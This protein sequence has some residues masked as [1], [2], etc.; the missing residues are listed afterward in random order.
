MIDELH[1]YRGLFGSHVA[2]V[3]RRL[4]RICQFYGA[5]PVFLCCSATIA[6][7][8]EL[9][10]RLCGRRPELVDQS[11]APRGPRTIALY[12]PP[13]VKAQLGLRQSVVTAATQIMERLQEAPLQSICFA[14]SRQ[15]VEILTQTLR[16][17]RPTHP[18]VASPVRGYR[19]GYL[20]SERR[21][22]E[23]GLRDG[24]IATVVATNALELGVDIGG[25]DAAVV[26]GYPGTR[27]ST[28]Q[29]LGRA[30]RREEPS[31][32]IVI[33]GST[34]VDQYLATHPDYLFDASVESGQINPDNPVI[35]GEHLKCAA[36]ELPLEQA[37]YAGLGA[38][39]AERVETL[40]ADGTVYRTDDRVYW[41]SEAFPAETVS[42][43]G[44]PDANVVILTQK[45]TPT[46]IGEVD[47]VSAMTMVH[48]D[49]IYVHDGRQYFVEA[50]DWDRLQARVHPVDVDYY[51]DA[52]LAVDLKVL[53]ESATAGEPMRHGHGEVA[54]TTLATVFKKVTLQTHENVGWGR[55]ALP[56]D[57][58]QTS[59]C[60]LTLAV[61]DDATHESMEGA[62][63][64]CGT[65]CGTS[66]PYV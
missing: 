31:L 29:Q 3:L 43:H 44:G 8:Q 16:A 61:P 62:L 47:R 14:P 24:S 19:G 59:A 46:V 57:T 15:R 58:L 13:V 51:T 55:I 45:P 41:A 18:G 34:P 22:I 53:D 5:D 48:P 12:N 23:A 32:G 27:A 21:A 49:A 25:L 17:S 40:V 28:W 63:L 26:A 38:G 11:G 30:G 56:Q 52:Q 4:H 36:F 64:G 9:A 1:H 2:Q 54:V 42:L 39:T 35:A 33:T 66:P 37:E 65:C 10:E 7:P 6:N 20:P 50:L 60:W